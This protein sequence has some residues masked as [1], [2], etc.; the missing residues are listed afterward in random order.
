MTQTGAATV[1]VAAKLPAT[2]AKVFDEIA[3]SRG[4]SRSAA[5]RELIETAVQDGTGFRSPEERAARDGARLASR[6]REDLR[7]G[8]ELA[9]L[10]GSRC[11]SFGLAAILRASVERRLV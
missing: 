4:V 6:L 11:S 5:I 3:L 2:L 1:T 9:A 7:R 10:P 8:Q